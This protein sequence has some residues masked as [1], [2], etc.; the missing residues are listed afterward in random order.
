[1]A[2]GYR[3]RERERRGYGRREGSIFSDDDRRGEED[4]GF[5]DRAGDEVR[6][7][8]GDEEAERRRER[9]ARWDEGRYGRGRDQDYG[10]DYERRPMSNRG[11][12]S[13]PWGGGEYGRQADYGS[14]GGYGRGGAGYPG[15]RSFGGSR[16]GYGEDRD[17]GEA[18]YGGY[19][20][21]RAD[22][23]RGGQWDDNYRRWRDRQIEQLDREYDEYCRHRQR[24]FESDFHDWRSN[25]ERTGATT[26]GTGQSGDSVRTGETASGRTRETGSATAG[27]TTA[28]GGTASAS[29]S[30]TGSGG[31]SGKGR[32]KSGS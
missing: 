12:G 26:G 15:S 6:S 20:G 10:R 16:A 9:D 2:Y 3:E 18:A 30:S 21:G 23:G 22:I 27:A 29:R 14:R 4:R 19:A 32:S 28:G 5:M 24:Q 13:E 1:M 17:V 8:F 11:R 7:W 25:R 31:E